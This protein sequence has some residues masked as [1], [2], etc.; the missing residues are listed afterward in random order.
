[1][2][3]WLEFKLHLRVKGN[4]EVV[5]RNTLF[6][7]L[8]P[9]STPIYNPWNTPYP[10]HSGS[11]GSELLLEMCCRLVDTASNYNLKPLPAGT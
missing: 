9:H 6:L 11:R 2:E 8:R 1:M 3:V 5:M 10:E 7:S 4:G